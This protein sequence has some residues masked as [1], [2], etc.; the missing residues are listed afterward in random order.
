MN[1]GPSSAFLGSYYKYIETSGNYENNRATL[2]STVAFEGIY[3]K[4][5]I[6][7]RLCGILKNISVTD[8][9]TD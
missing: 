2:Q 3:A 7:V 1:T 6:G 9:L 8:T 4:Y 5:K